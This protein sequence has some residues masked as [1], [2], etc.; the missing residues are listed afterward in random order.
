MTILPQGEL[1]PQ[2]L[3]RFYAAD[4]VLLYIGITNDAGTRWRDHAKLKGWWREVATIKVEHFDTR[5]DVEA[6][7]RAAIRAERPV[8]N[9]AHN[10]GAALP[11][12]VSGPPTDPAHFSGACWT[13]GYA[14]H[15]HRGHLPIESSWADG[16][17]STWHLCPQGHRW[18]EQWGDALYRIAGCKCEWCNSPDQR[19]LEIIAVS[20]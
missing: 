6:A 17:L 7:E 9:I 16:E 14:G 5:A 1:S 3:Y 10:R 15:K 13:C 8:H 2:T 18:K 20:G 4:E 19:K 12:T 11:I